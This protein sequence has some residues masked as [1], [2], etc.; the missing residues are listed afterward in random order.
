MYI[1][2][3]EI[4]DTPWCIASLHEMSKNITVALDEEHKI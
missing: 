1:V 3:E 4:E 2:V